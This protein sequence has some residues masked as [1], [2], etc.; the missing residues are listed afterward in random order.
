MNKK[1]P[2]LT[3]LLFFVIFTISAEEEIGYFIKKGD[4]S[5][6]KLYLKEI[7]EKYKNDESMTK[8]YIEHSV[9]TDGMY[10][11]YYDENKKRNTITHKSLNQLVIGTSNF[12]ILPLYKSG[13]LPRLQRLIASNEKEYK[14][15]E[16]IQSGFYIIYTFDENNKIL[17]K[18]MFASG[19]KYKKESSETKQILKSIDQYFSGCPILREHIINVANINESKTK[20]EV[21]AYF[22]KNFNNVICD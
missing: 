9:E 12:V 11:Y 17:T 10:L 19:Y 7:P 3:I 22:L 18:T 2:I 13:G 20:R 14:L 4:N 1:I 21:G 5:K 8:Y 6:V 16:F 15:T